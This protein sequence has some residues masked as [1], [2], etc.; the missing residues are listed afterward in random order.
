MMRPMAGGTVQSVDTTNR[1]ITLTD[2]SGDT[3][4]LSVPAGTKIVG[5]R[6]ISASDL[7]VGDQIQVRGVP[8][9]ISADSI[10]SGDLSSMPSGGPA[11]GAMGG[12]PGPAFARGGGQASNESGSSGEQSGRQGYGPQPMAARFMSGSSGGSAGGTASERGTIA[13]VSPL[14][15]SLS[16]GQTV[17]VK[18]SSNTKLRTVGSEDLSDIQKGDQI[19]A[20]VNRES[21]GTITA[22]Q[23]N[24]NMPMA[25]PGPGMMGGARFGGGP[26]GIGPGPL[27]PPPGPGFGPNSSGM[28]APG[29]DGGPPPPDNSMGAPPPS[30]G[31]DMSPPAND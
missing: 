18:T 10:M 16:G 13:S 27:A 14:T 2:S 11:F 4:T 15:I 6:T 29:Q 30:D 3:E 8:Q 20:Q 28:P 5:T 22:V 1:T 25:F 17:T 9:V 31:P 23:V 12:G 24:V 21:D 7:K 19:N 26:Q